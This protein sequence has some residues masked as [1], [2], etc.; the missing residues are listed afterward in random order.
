MVSCRL[1]CRLSR[2]GAGSAEIGVYDQIV[3]RFVSSGLLDGNAHQVAHS[4]PPQHL[5]VAMQ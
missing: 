2:R 4:N 3:E 5:H 1:T